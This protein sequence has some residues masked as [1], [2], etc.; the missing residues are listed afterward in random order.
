[1]KQVQVSDP[2]KDREQHEQI[3][4]AMKHELDQRLLRQMEE[5]GKWATVRK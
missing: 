3:K 1:M 4:A 2:K 5:L